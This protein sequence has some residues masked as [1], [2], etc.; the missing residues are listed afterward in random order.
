M[1]HTQLTSSDA[2]AFDR[3]YTLSRD[4]SAIQILPCDEF[5]ADLSPVSRLPRGARIQA[6]GAGRNRNTLKVAYEGQ[7]FLVFLEDLEAQRKAM[8]LAV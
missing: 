8:T 3:T 6:C 2:P 5:G 7:F 4:I 1:F